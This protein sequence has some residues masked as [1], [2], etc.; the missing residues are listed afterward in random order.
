M[1]GSVMGAG[2]VE[3]VI[4]LGHRRRVGVTVNQGAV[5]EFAGHV[6]ASRKNISSILA[7]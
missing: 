4:D 2:A 3:D 7:T 5:S 1:T 6:R